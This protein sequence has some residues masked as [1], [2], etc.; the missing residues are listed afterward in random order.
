[1][2][3]EDNLN[4]LLK[5]F[6]KGSFIFFIGIIISKIA[7][8][9]YKVIV[10]RTFNQEVYGLFSLA[11]MITGFFASI[12]S[13]GLQNGLLR[14]ISLYRGKG[15][16]EK[17][18]SIIKFS[19]NIILLVSF[20]GGILL[21]LFSEPISINIFHNSKL[22]IFL[23]W[24]SIFIPIFVF[25]GTF[26]VITLAYE[27]VGWYSFIGNILSPLIQVISLIIFVLI[28]LNTESIVFSY[29]FGFLVI[30]LAA[31][32]VSKYT[33][34]EIFKKPHIEKKERYELNKKLFSYSWPIMFLGLV[35]VLFSSIDSFAIGYFKTASD[36]GIY[37]AA[38][39]ISYFLLIVP[40]LFLQLFLPIITKE[41]SKENFKLIKDL[42]KQI[43]KWIF[44]LNLPVAIIMFLFPGVVINLL[45]GAGYI[46]AE[47]SLRLLSIGIFVYSIFLISENLLSMKGK[48]RLV[49]FNLS[50]TAVINIILNI[51][52]IPKY[53]INGA[54][55]STMF[56]YIFW[57][58]LSFF[59]AKHQTKVNP[60]KLDMLKI[61]LI[62]I[63]PT[64][65]LLYIRSIINITL[66]NV[67]ITGIIFVV[68]YF[69]L[70]VLT[71]SLDKN[72]LMILKAI[73]N[74]IFMKNN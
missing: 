9:L 13:L 58:L 70:I 22:T 47:N 46:Q 45:F 69:V 24:F 57:G 48:S 54:A 3:E 17:I 34:K 74:R 18:Q 63:I 16:T 72:D 7:T 71:H 12:L 11:I 2:Q 64:A 29:N 20:I 51:I 53:G 50:I 52:L 61:I 66:L 26:H 1:M 67:I 55:F 27:K 68:V 5:T 32:F 41:Y 21:F 6:V 43:G 30:F 59:M 60:L 65:I 33:I 62:A 8:Y 36:V 19:L 42:S 4:H 73:R 49:L 44:I 28:G 37:N 25:S 23:Q 15:E 56:S 39:P 14:Y 35:M 10:A 38:I 31:F 40:Y